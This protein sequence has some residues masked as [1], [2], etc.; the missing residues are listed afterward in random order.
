MSLP[1][2]SDILLT[3]A[4][5]AAGTFLGCAGESRVA[6]STFHGPVEVV[7]H[8]GDSLAAPENT[9]VAARL[10]WA[11][12]ADAVEIDVHLSRDKRIVA[13]HDPST[14]RTGGKDLAIARTDSA[15]LRRLDVGRH[16]GPEFAGERIP[17]LE[18]ILDT[19]PSGRRLFVEVK[20]GTEIVP[21]LS[22]V[23]TD[24]GK[25]SQVVV[26]GFGLGTMR[27]CKEAM[28][29]VPIYW[30]CGPRLTGPYGKGL[31][32]K[33]LRSGLDGLDVHRF[34]LTPAFVQDTHA[35]GLDLCVWTVDDAR[36]AVV[37][38][39]WGVDGITTNR[40]A[41]L[42]GQIGSA[43]A[44]GP[45]PDPGGTP[46]ARMTAELATPVAKARISVADDAAHTPVIRL[47]RSAW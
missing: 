45:A 30:L 14:A 34:G 29:D 44:D 18:E 47:A 37:L 13:M 6:Y 19:L 1:R 8:R 11:R 22:Q 4:V 3:T 41:R 16:S 12:G 7:A 31:I 39:A 35:A 25:R 27:A 5:I 9:L 20:C 38:G 23:L 40:P 46:Y 2:F 15:D 17:F 26:I 24:S 36:Q 42:W 43:A 33:A 28:P 10:A 32:V 21:I